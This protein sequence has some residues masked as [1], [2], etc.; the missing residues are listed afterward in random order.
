M[1]TT[2]QARGAQGLSRFEI[3]QDRG[4]LPSPDPVQTLPDPFSPWEELA[5]LLPKLLLA[6][7]LHARVRA[8]PT[9]D[10]DS[11]RDGPELRRAM[12]LLSFAAHAWVW[13]GAHP[14]GA[15]PESLARPWCQVAVRLGR[16]PVLSYASY[17]LDNWRRLDPAGPIALD[18]L[19]VLQNFL[20]GADEDWFIGIHIEI[21][22]RAGR[23]L[24]ALDAAQRAAQEQ[25]AKA[26]EQELEA[27]G[28]ALEAMLATLQRTPEFCDPYIYYQRVRPFI[29]GWKDHPALPNG[30]RYGG[31]DGPDAPPRR[32][33]GETGAQSAIVPCLDAV[34]GVQ[35]REDPL[36]HYLREMRDYMPPEHRAFLE[37]LEARPAVRAAVQAAGGGAT[38]PY[39]RC[40]E[41]LEAF[42][43]VHLDYAARYI[44]RQRPSGAANPTEVGTGGTPFMTYL[45]KHRDETAAHR[46][47][48]P[49]AKRCDRERL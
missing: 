36:R 35:H 7:Q 21:E 9:L 5:A 47:Q 2:E 10:P 14:E 30:L 15:I 18:N 17:A 23:L 28:D 16:P 1:K 37:S 3:R 34:L 33:R 48:R 26:L 22:A 44:Q 32:L 41:A 20:G 45:A 11:L 19:A 49:C 29:H 31:V 38:V 25:R 8:L 46:L 24:C 43:G 12:L 6:R 39:N 40:I 27:T 42:R 4:F 13:G